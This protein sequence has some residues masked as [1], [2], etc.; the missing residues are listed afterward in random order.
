[1][2]LNRMRNIQHT[3]MTRDGKDNVKVFWQWEKIENKMV[4]FKNCRRFLLRY[5]SKDITPVSIRLK[6]NNKTPKGNHII[7]KAEGALLNDRIRLINNT[8]NMFMYQRDTCIDQI[9]GI[10]DKETI[11]ECEK[12]I[13]MKRK[14]RHRKTLEC[15]RLSFERLCQKIT[16]VRV[17]AQT[18]TIRVPTQTSIM[19]TIF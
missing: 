4:D 19:V 15:Q 1:M 5:L 2:N 8:I 7:K 10:F 9:K 3:Y 13:N 14:S 18:L 6:N 12:F 11:E 16:H 17:A